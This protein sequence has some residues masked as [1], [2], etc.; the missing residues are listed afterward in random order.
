MAHDDQDPRP[1]APISRRDFLERSA[2]IG[3][4]AG[5]L[6]VPISGIFDQAG[7]VPLAAS[8]SI[9]GDLLTLE[10]AALAGSWRVSNGSLHGVGI[11]DR[12]N[13][14]TLP[15]TTSPFTLGMADGTTLAADTM[16]IVAGPRARTAQR[17]TGRVTP[18]RAFGRVGAL[19]D[20]S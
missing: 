3:V 13:G 8:C 18:R 16:R 14:G 12:V 5:A 17:P 15:L 4:G 7:R 2:L 11:V 10:N 20:A 6:A 19:G 9:H 1:S